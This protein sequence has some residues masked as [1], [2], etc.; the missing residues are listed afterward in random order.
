MYSMNVTINGD[1]SEVI[2]KIKEELKNEG[3]GVLT[4]INVKQTLKNKLGVEKNPYIILGACNPALAN[5]ALTAE[6]DIG[7]LLPCNVVVRQEDNNDITVAIM[8]PQ[9]AMGIIDNP[10]VTAVANEASEKLRR[11][12]AKLE[13]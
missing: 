11:V 12:K 4:E 9:A 5:R 8:D 10:E 13:S 1:F 2:E 7:V 6:P 3:F